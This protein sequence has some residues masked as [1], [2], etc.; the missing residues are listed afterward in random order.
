VHPS[1]ETKD[2]LEK[3]KMDCSI[4][5]IVDGKVGS[6][7]IIEVKNPDENRALHETI[8]SDDSADE[9]QS[10]KYDTEDSAALSA[11]A[12][13]SNSSIA[14]PL[15]T[16]TPR[17][18]KNVE[19]DINL[20]TD[21]DSIFIPLKIGLSK[22]L[23]TDDTYMTKHYLKDI[24]QN[25]GSIT[26]L[27]IREHKLGMLIK[28]ARNKFSLDAELVA[29]A[30]SVTKV[31]K[32]EFLKKKESR[33]GMIF[34]KEQTGDGDVQKI[35]LNN[36]TELTLNGHILDVGTIVKTEPLAV[37]KKTVVNPEGDPGRGTGGENVKPGHKQ[38]PGWL[39][40]DNS[41]VP[42]DALF[43]N[44]SERTFAI[45]FFVMAMEVF[46][47]KKEMNQ[48][49]IARGLE[50]ATFKMHNRDTK[51]YWE[52][53]HAICG[54]IVGKSNKPGIS[55]LADQI[56]KGKYA[57]PMEIIELPL[58]KLYESLKD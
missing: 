38:L 52:K 25:V 14:N 27:F 33:K 21:C 35:K 16:S 45:E 44:N 22:A 20:D 7:D 11:D 19:S 32:K 58:K 30:R 43:Q 17:E 10:A 31:M 55:L 1:E 57:C 53:V 29:L 48:T 12:I 49:N 54:T 36:N 9:R 40:E 50:T 26:P 2:H 34:K 6:V 5:D 4:N 41:S 18:I 56:M 8:T 37:P 13:K 51:K 28:K 23:G 15:E 3:N 42:M 24:R 47:T 46:A 39:T